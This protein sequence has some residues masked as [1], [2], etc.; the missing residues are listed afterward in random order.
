MKFCYS[1]H[2]RF[3]QLNLFLSFLIQFNDVI[4]LFPK[5]APIS[6]N[7]FFRSNFIGKLIRLFFR[8]KFLKILSIS[9]IS[10]CSHYSKSGFFVRSLTVP[11]FLNFLSH[12]VCPYNNQFHYSKPST[13][14]RKLLRLL[15]LFYLNSKKKYCSPFHSNSNSVNNIQVLLIGSFFRYF[16]IK[17]LFTVYLHFILASHWYW[18][19][20]DFNFKDPHCFLIINYIC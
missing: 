6:R 11:R 16:A 5:N 20:I 4:I 17:Y 1:N 18:A 12:L 15:L 19:K 9:F 3:Y 10:V 7:P 14:N 2:L 13:L 8:W